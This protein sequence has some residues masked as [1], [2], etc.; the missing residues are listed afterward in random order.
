MARPA[1]G[2]SPKAFAFTRD[3]DGDYGGDRRCQIHGHPDDKTPDYGSDER[4]LV[5]AGEAVG[6][7]NLARDDAADDALYI[8][9]T[10]AVHWIEGE[11]VRDP[12]VETLGVRYSL[13]TSP[14]ALEETIPKR[15]FGER[16]EITGLA[17]QRSSAS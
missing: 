12:D 14:H 7:R 13:P 3:L 10:V 8:H 4:S 2:V 5:A 1:E 6:C 9:A 17:A 16:D 15:L 11:G